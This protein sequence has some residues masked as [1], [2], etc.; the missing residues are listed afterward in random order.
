MKKIVFI[1]TAIL[2]MVIVACQKQSEQ[3]EK[4]ARTDIAFRL[5]DPATKT[6]LTGVKTLLWSAGDKI[7]VN[8]SSGYKTF[9]LSSGA[10]TQNAVFSI[11]EE[12]TVGEYA[13]AYYPDGMHPGYDSYSYVTLPAEYTWSASGIQAP[14]VG[15]LNQTYPYMSMLTGVIKVDIVNIPSSSKKL[16][17]KTLN[18]KKVSGTFHLISTEGATQNT[19]A[20]EDTATPSEQCV[21]IDFSAASYSNA[22]TF[23]IPVPAGSYTFSVQ[24]LDSDDNPI[25]GTLRKLTASTLGVSAKSVAY[26]PAISL[27][28]FSYTLLNSVT[29]KGAW[30]AIN[31]SDSDLNTATSGAYASWTALP[32][33][34]RIKVT[35]SVASGDLYYQDNSWGTSHV[36]KLS[37]T[38]VTETTL[39]ADALNSLS[40]TLRIKSG[41]ALTYSKVEILSPAAEKVLWIGESSTNVGDLAVSTYFTG[42]AAGNILTVYYT[43]GAAKDTWVD[44]QFKET[45]NWKWYF[46]GGH[47]SLGP[48]HK[49][50]ISFTVAASVVGQ[51]DVV[52]DAVTILSSMGL[53]VVGDSN[54]TITKITLR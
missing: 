39:T 40:G 3:T 22:R 53:Y 34:T 27:G 47:N 17:F 46:N 14:M 11:N 50:C 4:L 35:H 44:L 43:D 8:T 10:G 42:I 25:D 52:F 6:D 37:G 33:G 18:G 51:G 23:F 54:L 41:A 28:S 16:L 21:T 19:I 7:S 2:G 12:V 29:A 24:M 38:G 31:F 36:C 30:D 15:W 20:T 49:D 9:T 45:T 13:M 48:N 26:V 1:T 32:E 5:E